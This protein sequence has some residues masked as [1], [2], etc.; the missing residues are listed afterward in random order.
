MYKDK[1]E[2]AIMRIHRLEEELL[3]QKQYISS[4]K[5]KRKSDEL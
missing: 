1:Y 4:L 5:N 2:E 3:Y